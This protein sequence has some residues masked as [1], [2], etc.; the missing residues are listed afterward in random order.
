M[1]DEPDE[2]ASGLPANFNL[3]NQDDVVDSLMDEP[4]GAKINKFGARPPVGG[5]PP[6]GGVSTNL[7]G[8]I[9]ILKTGA[10]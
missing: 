3:A 10:K 1:M 2:K 8:P 5:L 7:V 9:K 6:S 4:A